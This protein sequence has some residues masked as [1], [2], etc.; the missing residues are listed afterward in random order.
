MVGFKDNRLTARHRFHPV[1]ADMSDIR[2][3]RAPEP[4]AGKG[5]ANRLQR[6]MRNG[7]GMNVH[8]AD[9]EILAG[10]KRA[11]AARR[12]AAVFG[13]D[14][15]PRALVGVNRQTI[16]AAQHAD[17][18]DMVDMLM[19]DEHRVKIADIHADLPQLRLDA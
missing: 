16:L 9:I 17:S 11:H 10:K 14:P 19:G 4:L 13:H 6:V 15:V 18:P 5:I 1:R 3:H 8:I 12:N 2:R 7:K